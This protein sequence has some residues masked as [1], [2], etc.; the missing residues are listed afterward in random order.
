M[1]YM[2]EDIKLIIKCFIV[3]VVSK[4]I[5]LLGTYLKSLIQ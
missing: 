5:F 2:K 1:I 4:Q 3:N